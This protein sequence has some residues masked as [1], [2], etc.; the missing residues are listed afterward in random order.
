MITINAFSKNIQVLSKGEAFAIAN[1]NEYL[2]RYNIM[3]GNQTISND[4]L[5]EVV[6]EYIISNMCDENSLFSNDNGYN[7][8]SILNICSVPTPEYSAVIIGNHDGLKYIGD[9]EDIES[10]LYNAIE[11]FVENE[12]KV[13]CDKHEIVKATISFNTTCEIA[14]EAY[15]LLKEY[16][17]ELGYDV[18]LDSLSMEEV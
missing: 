8:Y 7:I 14:E 16:F 12:I 4:S 1:N 15:N 5:L 2:K 10:A 9:S 18:K 3:Y 11:Q 17:D 6:K 13:Q